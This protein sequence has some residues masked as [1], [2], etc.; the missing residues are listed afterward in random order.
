MTQPTNWVSDEEFKQAIGQFRLVVGNILL[1]LRMYGQGDTVDGAIKEIVSL[2]ID[3]SL[4]L[5]DVDKPLIRK[6]RR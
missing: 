2:A 4:R 5:R 6:G 1:P 3:L